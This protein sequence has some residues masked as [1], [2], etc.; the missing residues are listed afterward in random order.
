[1]QHKQILDKYG[2]RILIGWMRMPSK[3]S[4]EEWIG[5]M[6]TTKNY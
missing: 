3:P 6:Y 4:N 5:M 1:M 2:N